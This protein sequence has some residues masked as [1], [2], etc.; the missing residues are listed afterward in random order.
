[1]EKS[2]NEF[3]KT[4]LKA[5]ENDTYYTLINDDVDYE[6]LFFRSGKK[7]SEIYETLINGIKISLDLTLIPIA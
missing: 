1:M 7:L 5:L 3:T 4:H 2:L 6:N